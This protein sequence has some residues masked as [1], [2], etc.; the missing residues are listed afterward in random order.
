MS[1]PQHIAAHLEDYLDGKLDDSD[2]ES[3]SAW[4]RESEA[5]GEALASWFVTEV[6]LLEVSRLADMRAVFEGFSFD[7]RAK[8][9]ESHASQPL[10]KVFSASPRRLFAAAAVLALLG[11]LYWLKPAAKEN[12]AAPN[13]LVRDSA[14]KADAPAPAMLGRLADCVWEDGMKPI[15]VGQ[16]IAAGTLVEIKSGLAQLVFES[17]AEVVAKGPCR[18]RIESSMLCRL[19]SGNVSAEVP[20]RAAGF[21]I[22]GPTSEVIDL[23][24]RFGFSVGSSGSSEV[25]VFQGEVISRELDE[26]GAV[27][28]KEFR[29]KTNQ[30]ILF[31]G[32]K[33]Q[34]QRL[35]SNEAKFALEV[36]PLW[37]HDK[38]EPLV[39]DK[40]IAL[41]LRAGHGV[42]TDRKNRVIAWQD[43]AIG[44]NRIANDAFQP[45]P[46]ARPQ[47]VPAALN[48]RPGIRFDGVGSYLTTTPITTT[49]D[50]TI[51]V[52]FQYAMPKKGKERIGGQIINYNG[53]P[54]RYLP[55][56][57]SP[58]V[59]QLG[60]KI[61]VWNGPVLSIAAKAFVGHDSSGADVS[62]GVVKSQSLGHDRTRVVAYVY[63]NKDNNARLY[64]DG[65]VVGEASA[66]TSI[67][68]TSRKVIG[69]HGIFDQWYF[70]G[71]LG[72][73]VIFNA[74]LRTPEVKELSRQLK[75]HYASL[76]RDSIN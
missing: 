65:N 59:L 71:D 39:V 32:A 66:P 3:I 49:N 7:A 38:I 34:A 45:D 33:K 54:S 17:G 68:V 61:D 42:Q 76:S 23:G 31:P 63:D 2:R 19:I 4:L 20:H 36:T 28:G 47:Y 48:G 60:E 40:N 21:T 11:A 13:S 8:T 62:A 52:V 67:A 41:W 44:S 10:R 69:K 75:D 9:V 25:H 6:N 53:P 29:L 55:D 27:V 35:A 26:R 16:D 5:H 64:V 56:V 74:A 30:A 43:L 12:A 58:G 57:H 1:V 51:V 37:L 46:K 18:L 24:T 22:R 14:S 70:Q 50:Q 15:R 73:L 72:E